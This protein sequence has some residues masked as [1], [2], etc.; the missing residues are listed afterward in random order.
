MR[1]IRLPYALFI[2]LF[3]T[4]T[5][6]GPAACGRRLPRLLALRVTAGLGRTQRGSRGVRLAPLLRPLGTSR[7]TPCLCPIDAIRITPRG[8]PLG[9]RLSPFRRRPLSAC[10]SLLRRCSLDSLCSSISP[11]PFR[12]IRPE[13]DPPRRT[14]RA[15]TCRLPLGLARRG[16]HHAGVITARV[17][18]RLLRSR[19]VLNTAD[20]D[21]T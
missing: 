17:G 2:S 12:T 9:T 7:S 20:A 18:S 21:A 5:P 14:L 16:A 13:A 15:D 8:Y 6:D 3:N 1:R 19:R 11:R 10:L 4:G